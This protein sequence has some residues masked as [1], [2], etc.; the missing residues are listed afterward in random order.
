MC[1][2][3]SLALWEAKAE[4]RTWPPP[5]DLELLLLCYFAFRSLQMKSRTVWGYVDAPV[6]VLRPLQDSAKAM[7]VLATSSVWK[8]ILKVSS[9]D[10]SCVYESE[11]AFYQG[12]RHFTSTVLCRSM[13]RWLFK[14]KGFWLNPQSSGD[15]LHW[16]S[17]EVKSKAEA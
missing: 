8:L 4:F 13:W 5:L 10:Q 6:E 12:F 7:H 14:T 9:Q 2:L 17:Q 11:H 16:S 1:F 15:R 3:R